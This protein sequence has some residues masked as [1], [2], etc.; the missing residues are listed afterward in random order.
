MCLLFPKVQRK[1]LREAG[2]RK[3]KRSEVLPFWG[4]YLSFKNKTVVPKQEELSKKIEQER[5]EKE[6]VHSSSPKPFFWKSTRLVTNH[7]SSARSHVTPHTHKY[8]ETGKR[9]KMGVSQIM[10][11][12]NNGSA[13]SAL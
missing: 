2:K 4:G 8:K 1:N 13:F 10:N 3:N 5:K 11:K 9:T 7:L 6:W 12:K